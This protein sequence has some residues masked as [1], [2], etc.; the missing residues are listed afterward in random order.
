MTTMRKLRVLLTLLLLA[1][2]LGLLLWGLLPQGTEF[3]VI[4]L[5]PEGLQIPT[6]TG[7]LPVLRGYI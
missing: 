5:G 2:S 1:L 6:P 3:T 4:P 7:W